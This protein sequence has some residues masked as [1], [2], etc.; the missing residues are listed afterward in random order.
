[1]RRN[2]GSRRLW[3]LC[4]LPMALSAAATY[5]WSAEASKTQTAQFEAFA[6][7]YTCRFD[8]AAYEY[9]I[10]FDP[11]GETETYRMLPYRADEQIIDGRRVN[12]YR[13]IVFPK[14]PGILTLAF[15]ASME[16]TTRASIENAVIGRD[17]VEKLDYT[18]RKVA[19]PSVAVSVAAQDTRIA[20]HLRLSVAADRK[21][22]GAFA[23]V[24][25]RVTLE[26]YG[27]L[28]ELPPFTLDIPGVR[29]FT[30]GEQ[31]KLVLGEKGFEG[32][33]S[34]QF[35]LVAESNFTVPALR[36]AYFDTE[37][38][39]SVELASA[40][41]PVTV[42]PSEARQS[43]AETADGG[44]GERVQPPADI[45]GWVNLLLALIAGI[46]IGRFLLPDEEERASRSLSDQ[47]RRCDRPDR[48]AA[49]LALL[50]G[51]KYRPVIDEIEAKLRA[52]QHVD[53]KAYK[54]LLRDADRPAERPGTVE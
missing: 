9:I 21:T 53:L 13:Y 4:F 2:R 23:P 42:L 50:D 39:R 16:H 5:R 22:V 6:V 28:D 48:F 47:L 52:G 1:M 36:L 29:R 7:E 41:I 11:P 19:L 17:N 10:A 24:Q 18:A 25:V 43:A 8:S 31:K 33:I 38:N 14:R 20:G 40:P 3:L 27:N 30:D 54:R 46:A 26:G 12:R 44:A 51:E 37:R 49:Y 32:S 35:A 45:W 34:Q 15:E